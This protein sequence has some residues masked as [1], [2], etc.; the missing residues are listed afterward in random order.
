MILDDAILE[1]LDEPTR[2]TLPILVQQLAAVRAVDPDRPCTSF[3]DHFDR[4]VADRNQPAKAVACYAPKLRSSG[5][6]ESGKIGEL[7]AR[8]KDLPSNPKNEG[9]TPA[10]NRVETSWNRQRLTDAR[11]KV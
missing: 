9:L 7:C 1:A 11:Y 5:S 8:S 6:M 3:R 4:T 10:T 2:A